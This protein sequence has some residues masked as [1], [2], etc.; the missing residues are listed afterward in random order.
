[1]SDHLSDWHAFRD[2]IVHPAS[3]LK[4]A[5]LERARANLARHA[6]AR[7]MLEDMQ[8][9]VAATLAEGPEHVARMIP[10]T[11]PGGVL[12]TNC[13]AC[14][15]NTI[16]GAY[17]SP[18]HN[19]VVVDEAEQ[20]TTERGGSLHLYDVT[21]HVKVAECS[22]AAYEQ[23]HL[24]RRTCVRVDHGAQGAYLLDIF[25]VAGGQIHDYVF[26]GLHSDFA[27]TGIALP[28]TDGPAPYG[29]H[30]V[31]RGTATAPWRLRWTMPEVGFSAW[32]LPL[33]SE[34]VL[35]GN[36]WG[37]RGWGHFNTPDKKVEV[38]YVIWR[39][40]GDA[41]ASTFLTVFEAHRGEPLVTGIELV[42]T[43][44]DAVVVEVQMAHGADILLAAL[45]SEPRTLQTSRGPLETDGTLTVASTGFLYLAGG[46][47]ARCRERQVALPAGRLTG[48]IR[49][50]VDGNQDSY[51]VVD[52]FPE[53][54][55]AG[56]I[57]RTVL[58][59]DGVST[60][61][62]AVQHSARDHEAT[63]LYTK[64]YGQGYDVQGGVSWTI[65]FSATA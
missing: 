2:Q 62:Y 22:S 10:T 23:A 1:M 36:G 25:R 35:I 60:T 33:E 56:V 52:G 40:T 16:H 18:A 41:L 53:D 37:E 21:P 29:I 47:L 11:T 43:E 39:R 4:P 32:A 20:R 51:L 61:G 59:D 6:W 28:T 38:P 46:T 34:E 50:I 64:R 44:G 55:L 15:G 26:H 5:D 13:P 3:V 27:R 45:T 49:E 12:F 30:S 54:A 9:S 42:Q 17:N 48:A 19:L 65:I 8:S 63:R 57:G 7:R 31:R 14:E 58:V 24:Y